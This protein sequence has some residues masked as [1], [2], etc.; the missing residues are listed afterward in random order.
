MRPAISRAGITAPRLSAQQLRDLLSYVRGINAGAGDNAGSGNVDSSAGPAASGQALFESKGC[1]GCHNGN[2]K[3]ETRSTRYDFTELAAAMWN[4][5]F[6]VS[7]EP[8]VLSY[9]EM[10]RLVGYL[11]SIQFYEERGDSEKGK[12]LFETRRCASCH[13]NPASGA[14]AR[15]EMAGKMNSFG[16]ATALWKHGPVMLARMRENKIAWPQFSGSDVA[17]LTAYLRGP[18]LKRR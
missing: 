12:R 4:H 16:L 11:V 10:R 18:Q 15:R 9:V 2:L 8:P 5:A 14:P 13:D 3:L 1:A 6:R 17:D 7:G